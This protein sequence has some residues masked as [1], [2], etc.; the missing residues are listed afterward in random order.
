MCRNSKRHAHLRHLDTSTT[1]S[2][3]LPRGGSLDRHKHAEV[4][5]VGERGDFDLQALLEQLHML[6]VKAGIL[7]VLAQ[8][9]A[10]T[11]VKRYKNVRDPQACAHLFVSQQLHTT[12]SLAEM[13][14]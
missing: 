10:M 2:A 9:V 13:Q 1:K 5:I 6:H 4:E 7:H 8:Q 11:S 14:G 3:C 12:R